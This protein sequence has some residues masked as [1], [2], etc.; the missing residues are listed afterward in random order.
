[1]GRPCYWKSRHAMKWVIATREHAEHVAGALRSS[2]VR[3]LVMAGYRDPQRECM[4]SWL[5][6]PDA[7]AILGDNGIPV[8]L[9]GLNGRL[10]WLLAT[11]DL[12]STPS[13]RR[14]LARGARRWVASLRQQGRSAENWAFSANH[15]ALRWL[16]SLGFTVHPPAPHGP[17]GMLFSF[18][19]LA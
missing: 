2:D 19:E 11:N 4:L 14:Q 12:T 16:K 5:H 10:V 17:Y 3:E 15:S 9:F 7:R 13:H 18:F 6:T 8:G 1:M